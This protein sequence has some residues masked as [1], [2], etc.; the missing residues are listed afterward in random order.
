[1]GARMAKASLKSL[2]VS[3]SVLDSDQ[4]GMLE[5]GHIRVRKEEPK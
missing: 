4:N 3:M 2:R 5:G 1:M